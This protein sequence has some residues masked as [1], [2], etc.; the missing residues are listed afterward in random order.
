MVLFNAALGFYQEHRA[1]QNL[2]AAV[3]SSVLLLEDA[4]KLLCRLAEGCRACSGKRCVSRDDAGAGNGGP[5]RSQRS[6]A[7]SSATPKR[8]SSAF[9][10]S[11]RS[12]ATAPIAMISAPS[13]SDSGRV[14][15][16]CCMNGA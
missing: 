1:E 10:A 11:S 12:I 14:W 2:A 13:A 4:R 8:R 7:A 9:S 5:V 15:N 6:R 3:A 16:H